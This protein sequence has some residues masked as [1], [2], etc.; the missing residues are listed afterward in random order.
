MS[1]NEALISFFAFWTRVVVV[2][3]ALELSW[4]SFSY[5]GFGVDLGV[6]RSLPTLRSACLVAAVSLASL[7]ILDSSLLILVSRDLT[8]F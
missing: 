4:M 2:D 3:G 8:I 1:V 5:A 6:T 7:L